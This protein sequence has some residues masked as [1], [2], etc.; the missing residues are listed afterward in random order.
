MKNF[1]ILNIAMFI[2]GNGMNLFA[3]DGTCHKCERIREYNRTHP[4]KYTYYDDYLQD[5]KEGKVTDINFD[6]DEEDRDDINLS[7]KDQT[8]NTH[9][10]T[11]PSRIPAKSN[12]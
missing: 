2:L 12:K 1:F 7:K 5:K 3:A 9:N 11:T 8:R 4:S 10:Q 6:N